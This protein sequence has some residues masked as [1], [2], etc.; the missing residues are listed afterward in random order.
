M[1]ILSRGV[2]VVAHTPKTRPSGG[3]PEDMTELTPELLDGI[4][5]GVNLAA[6][7][8]DPLRA[9]RNPDLQKGNAAGM[10]AKYLSGDSAAGQA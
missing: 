6:G 4:S 2:P 5:G 9:V 7:E 1:E 10:A 8:Y 3:D